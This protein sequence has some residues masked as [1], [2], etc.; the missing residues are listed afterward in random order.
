MCMQSPDCG[1]VVAGTKGQRR[2]DDKGREVG[3]AEY[4]DVC[5]M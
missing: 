3:V 5:F 1:R 2:H 4:A